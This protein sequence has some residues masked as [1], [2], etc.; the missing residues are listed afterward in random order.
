MI[1]LPPPISTFS[2]I[3]GGRCVFIEAH[4]A[5]ERYIHHKPRPPPQCTPTLGAIGHKPSHGHHSIIHEMAYT[6]IDPM[7]GDRLGHFLTAT[8]LDKAGANTH[9]W[10]KAPAPSR[11]YAKIGY[12]QRNQN[13]G[14]RYRLLQ[15]STAADVSIS[16]LIRHT[17][18]TTP[19]P[20]ISTITDID[21][22]GCGDIEVHQAYERTAGAPPPPYPRGH[23]ACVFRF[24]PCAASSALRPVE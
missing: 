18:E 2:D 15:I 8:A 6:P 9:S 12:A 1:T 19:P 24:A 14:H 22:G 21:G 17:N 10:V 23:A 20:P 16:R 11:A 13:C 3:D 4:Q 7:R 5:H